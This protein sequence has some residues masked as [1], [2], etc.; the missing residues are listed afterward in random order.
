MKF[1]CDRCKT[2]YSIG[3]DRV[4]GKILKIRCKNCANVITVREGMTDADAAQPE[5][6]G[7]PR[8]QRQT[9]MAPMPTSSTPAPGSGALGAA[10]QSAMST[11]TP[12]SALEE[13]WYVSNDGEQE[14]P[15]S[16]AEAQRWV[17]AKAFDADLHCWSEGFDD[18]LPV[19]K[20]SHFRGLR[21]KPLPPAA[22]PPLPR[23]GTGPVR[24]FATPA[25]GRPQLGAPVEDEP[26]PL[27]AATMASLEKTAPAPAPVQSTPGLALPGT[28]GIPGASMP[29]GSASG[30]IKAKGTNG[31][32][33]RSATTPAPGVQTKQVASFDTGDSATQIESE[34]FEDEGATLGEPVASAARR[35]ADPSSAVAANGKPTLGALANAPVS[36]DLDN[37]DDEDDGL[38]I[39]EVSRVVKLAD[40]MRQ[41][42]TSAAGNGA[43]QRR[44]QPIATGPLAQRVTGAMPSMNGTGARPALG[45]DGA[46]GANG[47]AD[48]GALGDA[49]H[50][51]GAAAHPPPVSHRR[52]MIALLAVAGLLLGAAIIVF[53]MIGSK[54]DGIDTGLRGGDQIDTTRPDDILHH[55]DTTAGAPNIPT[56]PFTGK[57]I[58]PTRPR[59]PGTPTTTHKDPEVKPPDGL[60]LRPDEIEAE[61]AKRSTSTQRCYMRSQK[62]ADAILIGDVKKIAVTLTVD[63][64]GN[65]TDVSL[66]EHGNDSL[67]KCLISAI[68]AWKFRESSA[69]ITAKITMVFQNG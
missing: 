26:K 56:N 31:S 41:P 38:S 1:L 29:T 6:A 25:G 52:G 54:D 50:E 59:V 5:V 42:R 46:L 39:G 36:A 23:L 11:S 37:D 27:F 47:L 44:T 35:G 9:T 49:G 67:G 62:G 53:V 15:F 43:A 55:N 16:L 4:R 32:A 19:D 61:A 51:P 63:R 45:A 20:V 34:P 30:G 68:R 10:F 8:R 60:S 2:R 64:V 48:P 24:S 65:V 58:T 40:I 7:A 17:A 12:P 13:E 69:G 22:P 66:S 3:D 33:V 28:N 14:G 18:W 21:K 57:P